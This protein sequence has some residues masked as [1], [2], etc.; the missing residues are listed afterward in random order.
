MSMKNGEKKRGK[1][2]SKTD[3]EFRIVEAPK[4]KEI[5]S[6]LSVQHDSPADTAEHSEVP[7]SKLI[8]SSSSKKSPL[9]LRVL[10]MVKR[11]RFS[12]SVCYR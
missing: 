12:N 11:R 8:V 3:E 6:R 9:Q 7:V 4:K 5:P 2:K 10:G 1:L